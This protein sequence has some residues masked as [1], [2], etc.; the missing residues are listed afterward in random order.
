[1]PKLDI[2]RLWRMGLKMWGGR[3]SQRF[4][5]RIFGCRGGLIR[6]FVCLGIG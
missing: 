4:W 3:G 6:M 5:F 2:G 1:M